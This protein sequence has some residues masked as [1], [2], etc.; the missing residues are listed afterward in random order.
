MVPTTTGS[1]Q[2]RIRNPSISTLYECK[3]RSCCGLTVTDAIF[4]PY[5]SHYPINGWV[6]L[7]NL[8]VKVIRAV[9]LARPVHVY[10]FIADMLETELT[11]R[12]LDEIVND[13]AL[14]KS[15]KLRTNCC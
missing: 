14:K 13:C 5:M 3:Q 11:Q 2:N 9:I 7:F 10:R 15:K 1:A 12:T 4:K 6:F 8:V